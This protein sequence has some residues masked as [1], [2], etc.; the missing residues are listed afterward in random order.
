MEREV[1]SAVTEGYGRAAG[2]YARA[3]PSYPDGAVDWL[4]VELGQPSQVV[5]VGAG[6]GKFTARLVER[7]VTVLAVEPVA[8]MRGRLSTLGPLVSPLEATA[9][10]LPLKDRISGRPCCITVA[11]LDGRLGS[12]R[13]IRPCTSLDG[14]GRT[15]LELS[16]RRRAVAA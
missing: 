9:E 1:H 8:A 10:N 13:R 11:P 14:C 5:E 2:I 4:L 6:T 15:D 3:R 12:A 7:N 16:R